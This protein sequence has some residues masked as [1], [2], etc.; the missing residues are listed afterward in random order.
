MLLTSIPNSKIT[1][2]VYLKKILTGNK[3][4]RP[5]NNDMPE[6]RNPAASMTNKNS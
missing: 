2:T 4:N 3:D 1:F 5:K 6:E